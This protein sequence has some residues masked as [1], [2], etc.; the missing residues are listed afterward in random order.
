MGFARNVRIT[1]MATLGVLMAAL[2]LK[3]E[4][5]HHLPATPNWNGALN[6]EPNYFFRT[7]T[8]AV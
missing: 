3:A 4:V 8:G 2:P 6:P 1:L 7:G 5:S